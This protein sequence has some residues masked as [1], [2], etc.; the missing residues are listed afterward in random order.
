MLTATSDLTYLEWLALPKAWRAFTLPPTL[1]GGDGED[2]DAGAGSDDAGDDDATGAAGA[3][4]SG[5]DDAHDD[6]A[7]DAE[8]VA[9]IRAESARQQR[10]ADKAEKA[11]AQARRDLDE[12][13]K[14]DAESQGEFEQLYKDEAAAHTETKT[15]VKTALTMAR[16]ETVAK[17]LNF[18]H[19][20][21]AKNLI[22]VD[23]DEVVDEDF[24]VNEKPIEKALKKLATDYEDFVEK[25]KAQGSNVGTG[26]RTFDREI[27]SRENRDPGNGSYQ[28]TAASARQKVRNYHEERQRAQQT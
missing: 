19:P 20:E 16:I 25:P 28:V 18:K 3:S 27:V 15:K 10:R 22:A 8:A 14:R 7:P 5:D 1:A 6:D 26:G 21:L 11:A 12:R 9:K 13:K 4:G 23:V 24:D 2:D 17:R